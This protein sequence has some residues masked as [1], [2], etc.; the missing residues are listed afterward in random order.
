M[1]NCDE[2]PSHGEI[3]C[4]VISERLQ[5]LELP[6]NFF[7]RQFEAF[8]AQTLK[9]LHDAFERTSCHSSAQDTVNMQSVY[10]YLRIL[11]ESTRTPIEMAPR[12]NEDHERRLALDG[13]AYTEIEF[14][15]F[16][17]DA[18]YWDAAQV[19]YQRNE[20]PRCAQTQDEETARV[21]NTGPT[22]EKT[23]QEPEQL[24][25]MAQKDIPC[26]KQ[27]CWKAQELH[28]IMYRAL[29]RK[30]R[31]QFLSVSDNEKIILLDDIEI[32]HKVLPWRQFLATHPNAEVFV[33]E[34]I[35]YAALCFI[36]N[37][38]DHSQNKQDRCDFIFFYHRPEGEYLRW[39]IGKRKHGDRRQNSTSDDQET[40]EKIQKIYKKLKRVCDRAS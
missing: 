6:S 39:H 31:E 24:L 16:Y 22:E 29:E 14:Y 4:E 18:S 33:G 27:G 20:L 8:K 2:Q 26:H 40:K 7:D 23:N 12:K 9:A 38:P 28:D 21:I 36:E 11:T 30:R 13:R 10:E 5:I 3:S 34:G 25:A 15:N 19:L 35:K 37:M 32:D 17:G 1:R